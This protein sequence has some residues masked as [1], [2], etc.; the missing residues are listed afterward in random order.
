MTTSDEKI[1][2]VGKNISEKAAL[3]WSVAD[4]L[5]GPFKPHE[6]GLVILPMTVIKRFHDCL[7]PTHQKVLDTY[8]KVEHLA[9]QEGFLCNASGYQFY[10]IS[11]FTFE[12][13]KADPENIAANFRAYVNGFSDNVLDILTRMDF[14]A[15]IDR[16]IDAGVLYQVITEFCTEKGDMSPDKISAVDM[17]YVFENL[18]QRFSESY[19][20]EAGAHFTSR[21]II[22]TMC[23]LLVSADKNAFDG[24]GHISKTVY[25]MTMG[26]SQMLT[27]MDERLKQ[28]DSD[29]TVTT[30]GQEFNPFTFGIAKSDTLIRGGDPN[31]MQYGDTL[32]DDKF[33]GYHFDYI[34]S[35]P[36][37]G[38][39][40]KREQKEVENE[41]KK[42]EAGRF[43]PGLPSKSDGQMLFLLNGVAKLKDDGE[44]AIIQNGSSLF[45]GDAG[46]GQSEIRRYL[47]END[48]LDA[49]VQL[50]NSAFYNTGIATYI[51]L[52]VK[53]KP[54]DHIGKVQLIDASQCFEPRR[55]NIGDK[56]VD[57]TGECRDLI[58]KAYG[59]HISHDYTATT[60]HGIAI[61]VKSRVLD[62]A[63]LGYSKITVETPLQDEDGSVILKKGNP[64]ADTSKRDT[65]NVPLTEDIDDYFKREVLPY[66]PNA[67]IDK[68]KTVV[69]Y[70]IPFTRTFYEYKQMEPSEK[71]ATRI[72]EHE[73]SLMKKLQDLFGER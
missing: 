47:I 55:K 23:D 49:V 54:E 8:K 72:E 15:T 42:G 29:A 53:K 12:T 59:R 63:E 36:P 33:A 57:I 21:D 22:Y 39:P 7:M 17:G 25:D 30:F 27:C 13:L 5:V 43:A 52:I 50:P 35:N 24:N 38:I 37:F 2:E 34:I 20:E 16:M 69:G 3:I 4:A 71:I 9:V 60:E 41:F 51:W 70:E 6:Y 18:V 62:S 73:R 26:T 68:K 48:W 10:N 11:P 32:S 46:S 44:M 45:T 14:N 67:W 61:K 64:V 66:N 65:E 28:L 1:A 56:R 31:N 58:V 40:W 19:D